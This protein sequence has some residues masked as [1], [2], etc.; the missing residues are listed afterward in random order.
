V[1][2]PREIAVAAAVALSGSL[3]FISFGALLWL[4]AHHLALWRTQNY[5]GLTYH[6]PT[7]L[8]L[9]K[10]LISAIVISIVLGL[11]GIVTA[12]GLFRMRRWARLSIIVWCVLSSLVCVFGLVYPRPE[13]EFRI[14]P[15][16]PLTV[17]LV[18]FP[19][20]TW[21]LLLFFRRSTKTGFGMLPAAQSTR[22]TSVREFLNP[23]WITGAAV[24]AMI[25]AG[26]LSVSWRASPL[27]EIER[28]KEAMAEVK[29]WHYHT[30][31]YFVHLPPE[32][33]DADFVCPVFRHSISRTTNSGGG[34][35]IR[36]DISY[37][38]R[39]Y[40]RVGDQWVPNQSLQAEI[41]S[42]TSMPIFECQNGPIGSDVN[43]LPY[44]AIIADG[45]VR[46]G[47]VRDVEGESCRDYDIAVPTPHDPAEKE[48]QFTMCINESDH[49]PRETRRI[50][51]GS[52]QGQVTTYTLWNA[53]SEPQLP[54][55][56][57]R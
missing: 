27:R 19:V 10:I 43:A 18:V 42:Q 12:F 16:F 8:V 22:R 47:G 21:W 53:F 41:N 45:T 36:E 38:G 29:S 35:L 26:L 30:V 14:N 24:L 32:I 50:L 55:G 15:V 56:F 25:G 1:N 17:M 49:L 54:A 5:P 44:E 3:L 34:P 23:A 4:F 37:F 52:D 11:A 40:N 6:D 7:I 9:K 28:S 20:N 57:P 2:R 39:T 46:R 31:R 13:S 33:D 48:F 51:P